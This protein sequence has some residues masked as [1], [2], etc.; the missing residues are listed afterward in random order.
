L[1][2]NQDLWPKNILFYCYVTI[3]DYKSA[4]RVAEG[5]AR[6]KPYDPLSYQQVGLAELWLG[7]MEI[8]L[9]NFSRAVEFENH[10]PEVHVYSAM[11]HQTLDQVERR[12]RAIQEA[13]NEYREIL[14]AN[15]KDFAANFGL[16]S[17]YLFWNRS[18]TKVLS[19][20]TAARESVTSSGVEDLPQDR[21]VYSF[22]FL[23]ALEGILQYRKGES[24]ASLDTLLTVLN[25]AP[26][27]IKADLAEIYY[28]IGQNY[29]HLSTI[30][31]AK[32]FL[33]KASETDPT[34]VYAK[35]IKKSIRS[36][37]SHKKSAP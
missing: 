29:L 17:L 36:V 19:L 33:S 25:Q 2:Q 13:E 31:E 16:A 18:I 26:S 32:T 35:E 14:D 12:E 3:G 37:S 4:L 34:G 15:P 20:L 1:D 28:Y 9:S 7:R 23:P 6:E 11:A 10:S 21:K 8:A 30:G 27:G 5:I 22:F 24:Q